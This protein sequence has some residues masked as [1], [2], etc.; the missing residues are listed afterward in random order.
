MCTKN[1]NDDGSSG[2]GDC[3]GQMPF[4]KKKKNTVDL[5]KKNDMPAINEQNEQN[6][7]FTEH[8]RAL[9]RI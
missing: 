4:I 1:V 5:S 6:V 8:F 7:S 3:R 9:T 2:A